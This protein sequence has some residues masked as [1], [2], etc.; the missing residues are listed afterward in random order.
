MCARIIIDG[1]DRVLHTEMILRAAAAYWRDVCIVCERRID[2]TVFFCNFVTQPD[3]NQRAARVAGRSKVTH[4][5]Q[6][7]HVPPSQSASDF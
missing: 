3:I 5:H 1:Y 4:H 6:A 7:R 2:V